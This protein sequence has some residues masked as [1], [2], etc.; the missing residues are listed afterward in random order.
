MKDKI[1]NI[2]AIINANAIKP[3]NGQTW[4]QLQIDL[5]FK[6]SGYIAPLKSMNDCAEFLEASTPN[7]KPHSR[8]RYNG[9]FVIRRDHRL[10]KFNGESIESDYRKSPKSGW[11]TNID[12]AY[13]WTRYEAEVIIVAGKSQ[14]IVRLVAV[15]V[16]ETTHK[17]GAPSIP[18][19]L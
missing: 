7:S 17:A 16:Y 5:L 19:A 6:R 1:H 8:D 4:I 12:D 3:R 9:K 14:N 13:L 2:H 18:K 10:L 11:S 15:P